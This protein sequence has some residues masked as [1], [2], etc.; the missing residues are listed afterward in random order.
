MSYSFKKSH[1]RLL[2]MTLAFL[3]VFGMF[4]GCKKD[5]AKETVP[6]TE[7]NLPPGLVEV[8][9]TETTAPPE[10]TAPMDENAAIVIVD[11]AEVRQTPSMDDKPI[12]SVEKG[13]QV[14]IVREVNIGG[15]GWTLIREGWVTSD[16]IEKAVAP[17]DKGDDKTNEDKTPEAT[18]PNDKD[19]DK[20]NDKTTTTDNGNG[21]KAI[22][23]A[24][25]LNIRKEANQNSDRVDVYKKGDRITILETK[26]TW[27][28]TNKGWVSLNYVYQD[29]TQ[30]ANPANGVI[31][32]NGLN[33]RSGPG[34]NYDRVE[35]LN[36]GARVNILERITVN[37]KEWGCIKGGW[38]SMEYVYVDGTQGAA[39]GTGT[40]NGDQVNVRSG[41]GTNFG[42]VGSKNTG[43]AVTI[44][45]QFQ[46]GQMTWGCIGNGQ[47]I[48]MQFVNM[49]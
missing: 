17:D 39:A 33:V 20:N 38:I 9:P 26:G 21:T 23:T 47:W 24:S 27:G 22:V 48:A 49:G 13:K 1:L 4:A 30:G 10:T 36:F 32:G 11:K 37:G 34:T 43:D 7:D 35:T 3:L 5:S 29:G 46:I 14:T 16:S 19:N 2:S 44:Y 45:A 42:S 15:T 6:T 28:R 41:P 25:E 18:K 40:V 31:T 8:K 12:G